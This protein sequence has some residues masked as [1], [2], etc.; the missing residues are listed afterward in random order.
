MNLIKNLK[1]VQFIDILNMAEQKY[2]PDIIAHCDIDRMPSFGFTNLGV[3]CYFNTLIQGLLSCTSFIKVMWNNK[4]NVLYLQNPLA[5]EFI[6]TIALGK[7]LSNLYDINDSKN[8]ID[9]IKR[10]LQDAAP[11][12]FRIVS[13]FKQSLRHGQQDTNEAFM[14]VLEILENLPGIDRLFTHTY[15]RSIVCEE[16]QLLASKKNENY[17]IFIVDPEFKEDQIDRFKIL[18]TYYGKPTSLQEYIISHHSH[19]DKHYRCSH[20]NQSGKRRFRH[21]CLI[22]LPEIMPILFKK[23]ERKISTPYEQTMMFE[24]K[25]I[26]DK[27]AY[28]QY[29]LVAKSEH[30]GGMSGGHYWSIANRREGWQTLNDSSVSPGSPNVTSE[31]YMLFYHF[32]KIIYRDYAEVQLEKDIAKNLRMEQVKKLLQ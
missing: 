13:G 28:H 16:C 22:V 5:V 3:T 23:Y 18:N 29:K 15:Q 12:M 26:G 10:E 24:A 4:N 7:K 11:R 25:I 1:E 32:D 19:V 20:C 8:N 17:K 30:S 9:A 21:E 14:G 6:K 2:D 27:I 31:T